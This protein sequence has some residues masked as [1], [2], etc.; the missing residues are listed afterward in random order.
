MVDLTRRH[1][2]RK[3]LNATASRALD[4]QGRAALIARYSKGRSTR[5]APEDMPCFGLG[6]A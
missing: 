2:D 5:A 6:R 4:P 3:P 1:E